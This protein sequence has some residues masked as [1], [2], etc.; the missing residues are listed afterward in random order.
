MKTLEY[1]IKGNSFPV[2]E[3]EKII[4]INKKAHMATAE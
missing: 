4:T 3:P 2:K 1:A